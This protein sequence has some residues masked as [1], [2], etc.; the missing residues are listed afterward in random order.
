MC[1]IFLTLPPA[2]PIRAGRLASNAGSGYLH[3]RK[4]QG[5]INTLTPGRLGEFVEAFFPA[6]YSRK[7][8]PAVFQHYR[9][10]F[11]VLLVEEPVNQALERV[12]CDNFQQVPEFSP[13]GYLLPAPAVPKP[14]RRL[15][16]HTGRLFSKECR[17]KWQGANRRRASVTRTA[18]P[19]EDRLVAC[20]YAHNAYFFLT[21]MRMVRINNHERTG[22]HQ[23]AGSCGLRQPGRNQPRQAGSPGRK[24]NRCS[25]AQGRYPPGNPQGHCQTDRHQTALSR[26]RLGALERIC[27]IPLLST[28]MQ[29]R[30]TA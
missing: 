19:V 3:N 13:H 21:V 23:K 8:A 1:E 17:E 26:N 18:T 10:R 22:T 29:A 6:S 12:D 9:G 5:A 28:R 15:A 2:A 4:G 11:L 30:T 25:P 14:E 24:K 16:P 20:F 27:V 7:L